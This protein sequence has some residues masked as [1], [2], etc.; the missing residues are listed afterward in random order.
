[1]TAQVPFIWDYGHKKQTVPSVHITLFTNVWSFLQ[2]KPNGWALNK[3]VEK[4]SVNPCGSVRGQKEHQ[5]DE[6]TI[7]R[8]HPSPSCPGELL[9]PLLV[10][11]WWSERR[12]QSSQSVLSGWKSSVQRS[13][14]QAVGSEG[15][16]NVV[17]M[18]IKIL[19][20]S[21]AWKKKN[22]QIYTNIL[23]VLLI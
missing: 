21:L 4:C 11:P 23:H 14:K 22:P 19:R 3:Q 8:P 20:Q 12:Q 5:L 13:M 2:H 17:I 10:L 7:S 16:Q 15:S 9:V 6:I 1:M 18:D